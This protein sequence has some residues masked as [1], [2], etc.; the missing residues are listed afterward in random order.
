[1][2][3]AMRAL[4]GVGAALI[5]PAT[6][7]LITNVFTDPVERQKAIAVWASTAGIGIALGPLAGG[8]LLEH[9]Y[10]GSIFLVNLPV[11]A[12][13]L[14]GLAVYVPESRDPVH[15]RLDLAG[16][17]LSIVGLAMLVYG[18]IRGGSDGWTDPSTL[19]DDRGPGS[20]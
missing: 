1:M 13:A 16:A 15:R 18:V 11:I 12:I 10:W 20:R 6:L 3:I 9:F 2:L 5:F 17:V 14:V 8:V 19:G 4:T 7:S